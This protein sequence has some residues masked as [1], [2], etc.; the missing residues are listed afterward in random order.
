MRSVIVIVLNALAVQA[1]AQD[2]VDR[3]A[4][5][6]IDKLLNK[7]F[8]RAVKSR[9]YREDLDGTTLGMPGHLM[10]AGRASP[11]RM[12]P[13]LRAEKDSNFLGARPAIK[14]EGRAED[15][16]KEGKASDSIGFRFDPA[17]MK[18]VRDDKSG[19]KVG[20]WA[21]RGGAMNNSP[22][23]GS[24]YM[25][26]PAVYLSLMDNGLMNKQVTGEE[27]LKMVKNQGAVLVDT[28]NEGD[29]EANTMEGAVN[30]PLYR[31]VAGNSFFDN[32]KKASG[33]FMGM[34]ATERN[35]DFV[36]LAEE[37]LPKD[38]PIIVA[39]RRGGSLET[40]VKK[41]KF[42]GVKEYEDPDKSFGIE[43][44]SLKACYE[45]F[46]AGFTKVYFLKGGINEWS[47]QKLPLAPGV[48]ST[49]VSA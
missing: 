41:Q 24:A 18:W 22:L 43:S 37:R 31:P 29:F 46:E 15:L 44:R 38:K 4:D 20:N 42:D 7:M 27:A 11:N 16:A 26:W 25:V 40:V 5:K 45:L 28:D 6:L 33:F 48:V 8:D 21:E 30:V 34:T 23:T 14:N 32:V 13:V 19:D 17:T 3:L 12:M 39:C 2:S 10:V 1:H 47:H 49:A 36:K 9:P 35:T